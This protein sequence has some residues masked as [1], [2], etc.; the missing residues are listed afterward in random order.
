M[1]DAIGNDLDIGDYVV[2]VLNDW[3]NNQHLDR[4]SVV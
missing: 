3:P 2:V 4:K 1:L